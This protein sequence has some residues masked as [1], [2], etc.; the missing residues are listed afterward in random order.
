[1]AAHCCPFNRERAHCVRCVCARGIR[2]CV[3][4]HPKSWEVQEQLSVSDV[5]PPF[6]HKVMCPVPV[7]SAPTN[8]H[9]SSPSTFLTTS[10]IVRQI[11]LSVK[12]AAILLYIICSIL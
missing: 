10:M 9:V 8:S 2:Q 12:F 3:S 5:V 1:M 6:L 7:V 4:C 11:P